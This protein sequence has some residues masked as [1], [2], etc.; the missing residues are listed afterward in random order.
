MST[1]YSNRMS[2]GFPRGSPGDEFRSGTLSP[3]KS[4]IQDRANETMIRNRG[5]KVGSMYRNSKS[6]HYSQ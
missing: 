1:I 6:L 4:R 5:E 3:N 2:D